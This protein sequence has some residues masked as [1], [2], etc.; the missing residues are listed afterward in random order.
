MRG[1]LQHPSHK[2]FHHLSLKVLQGIHTNSLM[3]FL[4]GS[5][6]VTMTFLFFTIPFSSGLGL[7]FFSPAQETCGDSSFLLSTRF[8]WTGFPGTL[9][10]VFFLGNYTEALQIRGFLEIVGNT[11]SLFGVWQYL[12]VLG[13]SPWYFYSC[14][15]LCSLLRTRSSPSTSLLPGGAQNCLQDLGVTVLLLL[16]KGYKEFQAGILQLLQW[17]ESFWSQANQKYVRNI[18]ILLI[19]EISKLE[20]GHSLIKCLKTRTHQAPI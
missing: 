6:S 17:L 1:I 2:Q 11:W 15:K 3:F 5:L 8:S 18:R 7:S 20:L 14:L 19:L 13:L 10:F 16:A 12:W 9:W 4:T